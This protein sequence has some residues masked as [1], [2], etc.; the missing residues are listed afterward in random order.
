MELILSLI[1]G[2]IAGNVAGGLIKETGLGT[3][4]NSLAGLAGAGLGA[5]LVSVLGPER[6]VT[7]AGGG[8]AGAITGSLAIGAVSGSAVV[9]GIGLIHMLLAE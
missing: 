3:I 7:L 8:D 4:G 9:L 6:I 2:A 1:A 5:Y